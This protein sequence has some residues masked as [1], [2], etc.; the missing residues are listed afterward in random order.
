VIGDWVCGIGKN[1][2]VGDIDGCCDCMKG[3]GEFC[4]F[5]DA[6]DGSIVETRWIAGET[7]GD[8]M[9]GFIN[10]PLTAGNAGGI[11]VHAW[12]FG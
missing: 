9:G 5:D 4:R 10:C 6:N 3:F 1:G 2:L 11:E 12:E 7:L 8:G